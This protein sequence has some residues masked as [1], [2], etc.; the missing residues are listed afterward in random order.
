MSRTRRSLFAVV[1]GGLLYGSSGCVFPTPE[2][3]RFRTVGFNGINEISENDDSLRYEIYPRAGGVG[4]S[5][6]EMTFHNLTVIGLRDEEVVC[7][8]DVGTVGPEDDSSIEVSCPV[9][10]DTF[11]YQTIVSS[12]DEDTNVEKIVHKQDPEQGSLWKIVRMDCSE[13]GD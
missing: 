7:S 2:A 6:E 9:R 12:C 8:T 11:Q 5:P 1:T 4:M 10:P 3:G 13:F